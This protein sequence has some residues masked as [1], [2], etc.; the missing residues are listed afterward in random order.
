MSRTKL[1]VQ[2]QESELRSR[3]RE[4][5]LRT[6]ARGAASMSGMV[7]DMPG[8]VRVM[9]GCRARVAEETA[10]LSSRCS[11]EEEDSGAEDSGATASSREEEEA[12]EMGIVEVH[13]I[14][15]RSRTNGEV[16]GEIVAG[17]M[18]EMQAAAEKQPIKPSTESCCVFFQWP[19]KQTGWCGLP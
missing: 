18:G 10:P 4:V 3:R 14:K 8:V 6:Q 16:L 13:V 19:V 9:S 12:V 17:E 1:N 7:R 15:M 5:K 11:R 2:L